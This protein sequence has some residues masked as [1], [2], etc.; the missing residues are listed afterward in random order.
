MRCLRGR[1]PHGTFLQ[2]LA[3]CPSCAG[4]RA[5]E[6]A[7]FLHDEVLEEGGHAR[8]VFSLPKMVRP[9]FL[10]HRPLLGRLCRAACE[11]VREPMAEAVADPGFQPGM[12]AVV[13]TF[14][15]ALT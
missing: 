1:V 9:Y 10:Y 3:L 7:V 12:I 4:K 15:D 14:G 6:L 5:T 2:G 8:W 13:Q 11:T